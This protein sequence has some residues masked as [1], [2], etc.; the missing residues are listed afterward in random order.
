MGT[1]SGIMLAD[2]RQNL[3]IGALA[4]AQRPTNPRPVATRRDLQNPT[5]V[6]DGPAVAMGP[7][8]REPH[9]FWLA[10]NCVAS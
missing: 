3:Q 7:D 5:Q 2:M 4:L 1:A 10:K 8:K 9:I 6:G